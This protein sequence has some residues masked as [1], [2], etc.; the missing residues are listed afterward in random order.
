MRSAHAEVAGASLMVAP[1][2]LHT[3]T[4]NVTVLRREQERLQAELSARAREAEDARQ[5]AAAAGMRALA[6]TA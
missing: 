5:S 1:F 6:G 3:L 4:T 2:K